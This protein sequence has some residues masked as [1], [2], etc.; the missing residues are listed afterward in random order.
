MSRAYAESST[1]SSIRPE[2]MAEGRPKGA[3]EGK[4][5]VGPLGAGRDKYSP[6]VNPEKVT[7]EVLKR[8]N[9]GVTYRNIFSP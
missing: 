1:L 9:S 8:R 6:P 4:G 2:L 7:S 5:K 3:V